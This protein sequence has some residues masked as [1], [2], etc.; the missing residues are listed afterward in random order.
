M[1]ILF[2]NDDGINAPGLTI[3]ED[4]AKELA[5]ADGTVYTVAPSLEQS[6]VAH[7]TSH[8][9]PCLITQLAPTRYALE[10]APADCVIAGIHHVMDGALPDLILSGVNR[11]NN[12]AE[13]AMYS[14]TLGAAMEGAL[15]GV[16]SFALSQYY[17]VAN[18]GLD[19][20]FEAS[21]RHA[22]PVIRKLLEQTSWAHPSG[23]N[24]F[25]NI[26]FPPVPAD[27]VKGTK[28]VRQ[29]RREG[30]LFRMVA[31]DSPNGRRFLWVQ[32]SSQTLP[33]GAGTDAHANLD[34]YI[35]VTPMRADLT[36]DD[37]LSD[38]AQT[39]TD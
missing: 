20:P 7:L 12:A 26:N 6:G 24:T 39:F 32:G 38:M 27:A 13:N 33:S 16:P 37:T 14:G 25:F 4:I 17:G 15:Q 31:Q 2:T 5:G 18:V 30:A 34:G 11:G 19:N 9:R 36:A 22:T 1:K 10:G 23:Y 3:M 21:A 35:A 8:A 29:G 28:I